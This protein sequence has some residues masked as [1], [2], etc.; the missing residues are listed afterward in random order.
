MDELWG[1]GF[2][3]SRRDVRSKTYKGEPPTRIIEESALVLSV[4]VS[5]YSD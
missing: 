4:Q 5:P 3:V 2:R 1:A